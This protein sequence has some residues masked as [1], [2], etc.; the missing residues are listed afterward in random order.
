MATVTLAPRIKQRLTQTDRSISTT[1]FDGS[2]AVL[3][4]TYVVLVLLKSDEWLLLIHDQTST[5]GREL[6]NIR[7]LALRACLIPARYPYT[8]VPCR[9]WTRIPISKHR[10][11]GPSTLELVLEHIPR[12]LLQDTCVLQIDILH[13]VVRKRRL[14]CHLSSLVVPHHVLV[15]RFEHY[16]L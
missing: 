11:L 12:L 9:Q 6:N 13:E 4:I 5:V 3:Y 16:G 8:V 2:E 10:S 1:S 15:Y 7:K 14:L